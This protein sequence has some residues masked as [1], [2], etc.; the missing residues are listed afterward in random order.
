M[1][2]RMLSAL[3]A[4]VAVMATTLPAAQAETTTLTFNRWLPDQHP[5]NVR[6]VLPWFERI[7]EVTGG[8]VKVEYT[9]QGLVPPP[10]QIDVVQAGAADMALNVHGFT[11]G[12]FNASRIGELPFLSRD[13]E[14]L[15]VA[16]WRTHQ[17]LLDKAGEYKGVKVLTLFA[18]RP[19]ALW[20]H[21]DPVRSMGDW[22]GLKIFCGVK[23][24]CVLAERLGATAVQRP[25]PQVREM[26]EK[27]IVDAA[28][29]DHSSYKDFGLQP[30]IEY[31]MEAPKGFYAPTF[32]IIV[33]EAKWNALS[34][35]DREAIMGISGETLA[36][37]AGAN[38]DDEARKAMEQMKENG[39][40]RIVAEGAYLEQLEQALVLPA[41]AEYY[42]TAGEAGIDGEAALDYLREQIAKEAQ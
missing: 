2:I 27:K 3:A 11:P 34:D 18:G 26:L 20:S 8:R 40:E 21:S 4:A 16:L 9:A 31:A 32:Y 33:N 14:P 6:T 23:S 35:A 25:G 19:G 7:E 24:N 38:W 41:E 5:I 37:T 1:Y 17:E 42:E 15:S 28:F 39:V 36:R 29:I 13:A 10:K 12:R 30:Y 22:K